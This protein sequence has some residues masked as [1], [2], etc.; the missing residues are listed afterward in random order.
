MSLNLPYLLN[1]IAYAR[2]EQAY[3]TVF[4]HFHPGL[5]RFCI[6]MVKDV[7]SAEEIVSDTLLKIWIMESRLSYVNDIKAYLFKAAKNASLTWLSRQKVKLLNINEVEPK[8]SETTA[9]TM[10]VNTETGW[11][12]E[13]AISGLPQQCQLV[14]RLAKQEELS[15][16]QITSIMEISQN[17]IE[18]HMRTALR[19]IKQQLQEYLADKK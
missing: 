10:Y 15:Y 16:K 7:E 17:T 12:I 2:D 13:K 1:R 5:F 18:S 6:S 9:E 14:F 19:R 8:G 3:K 4:L 11:E